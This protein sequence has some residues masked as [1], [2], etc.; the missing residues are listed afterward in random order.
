MILAQLADATGDR[1]SLRFLTDL[2]QGRRSET[3]N[4]LLAQLRLQ[5]LF[6]VE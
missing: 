2:V 3:A 4:N 1:G 6:I 5:K